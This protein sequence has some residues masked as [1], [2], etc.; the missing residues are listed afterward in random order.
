MQGKFITFEGIDGSGKSTQLRM[1][2]GDL[3]ARGLDVI[4]TMEPGGTPL[5]RRLREAFL[6]TE[7]NV[8]PIAELLLFAADRAQHVE[9]LVKPALEQG[10][11]VISDRY[12]DATFAY[13]G[14]GRGFDEKTVSS[15]IKLAT[16]GLKPDL[17]LFFDIAVERAIQ[18]TNS[19]DGNGGPRNRMDLET[20]EFYT[21]VRKAYLRIAEKEPKRFKVI[22]ANGSL[23]ETHRKV[24]EIIGTFLDAKN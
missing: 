1:L 18:R 14:A 9:L 10:R 19:R 12:A 22:D 11:I 23:E 6:E 17:T 7:E 2:T 8:A 15:V 4:T 3:R 16:G 20:A 13:Q 24:N 5:G 21:E